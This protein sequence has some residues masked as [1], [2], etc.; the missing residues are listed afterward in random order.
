MVTL[1]QLEH[2]SVLMVFLPVN[3]YTLFA[4]TARNLQEGPHLYHK[5]YTLFTL[6][7]MIEEKQRIA[8]PRSGRK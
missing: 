5:A 2:E 1:A 8:G 4:Q 3:K 7:N 6:A